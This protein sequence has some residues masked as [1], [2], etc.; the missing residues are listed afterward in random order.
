MNITVEVSVEW[1]IETLHEGNC[2][3][4]VGTVPKYLTSSFPS[5]PA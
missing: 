3:V 2:H 4:D 5:I 1:Q